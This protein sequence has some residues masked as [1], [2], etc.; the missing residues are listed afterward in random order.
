MCEHKENV[1]SKSDN[2]FIGEEPRMSQV[3]DRNEQ[4]DQIYILYCY[5]LTTVLCL[6][7]IHIPVMIQNVRHNWFLCMTI[8][9][10]ADFYSTA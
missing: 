10:L 1:S 9:F 3:L 4:P 7:Y 2:I 6:C 5:R 8:C